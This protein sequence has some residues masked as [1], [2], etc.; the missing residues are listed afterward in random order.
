MD[1]YSYV[2]KLGQIALGSIV[3]FAL[4]VVFHFLH[5]QEEWKAMRK[6]RHFV[7]DAGAWGVASDFAS[8]IFYVIGIVQASKNG[9]ASVTAFVFVAA[10]V[11]L[12]WIGAYLAWDKVK[13]KVQGSEDQIADL[14]TAYVKIL[15]VH[16]PQDNQYTET[17]TGTQHR[18]DV[19]NSSTA[20][21]AR[22]VEAKLIRVEPGVSS[23]RLPVPLAH[24]HDRSHP[25]QTKFQLNPEDHKYIDLILN[26]SDL[27]G[28]VIC[29][30]VTGIAN[31]LPS[32]DYVL[33]VQVTGENIPVECRRF[34]VWD[35]DGTMQCEMLPETMQPS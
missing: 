26:R 34:R 31:H 10:S 30:T 21:S 32:G 15:G 22:D 4:G 8:F 2:E 6:L 13:G 23:L 35:T 12:F 17:I 9:A 1:Y 14:K 29:H 27:S 3:L 20:K 18:I 28:M 33:T 5:N 25:Q 19:H 11:P 24:M 16:V 7:S